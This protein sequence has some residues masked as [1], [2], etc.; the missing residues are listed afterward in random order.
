MKGRDTT[1][2]GEDCEQSKK[3]N[4][5]MGLSPMLAIILRKFFEAIKKRTGNIPGPFPNKLFS[6]FIQF[7]C[8]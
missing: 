6:L 4:A 2:A 1:V 3:M 8:S 7:T 5:S